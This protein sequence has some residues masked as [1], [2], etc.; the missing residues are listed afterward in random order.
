LNSAFEKIIKVRIHFAKL[1]IKEVLAFKRKLSVAK[2]GGSLLDVEGKGIPKV[3]KRL[4]ELK[5]KDDIG[6]IAVFSAPMGCT[7]ELTRIGESYA[8]S[9]PVSISPVFEVYEHIA[10]L[11]V[12]GKYLEQA[13][14]ALAGYKA[15]TQETLAAV[16]NGSAATSKQR[17]LLSVG[18]L[19][20]PC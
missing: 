19:Q 5:A 3:L 7:D 17:S 8:Q 4:Q 15:Q 10:K 14:A 16:I 18:N 13:L 12:K 11:H 1:Y 20:C 6:L 2:F 9:A